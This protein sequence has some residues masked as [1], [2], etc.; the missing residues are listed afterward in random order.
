M[1][2][3]STTTATRVPAH[4]DLHTIPMQEVVEHTA[5]KVPNFLARYEWA[6][7]E[8]TTHG[9]SHGARSLLFAVCYRAGGK[10]GVCFA[11][12]KTLAEDADLHESR[13]KKL[14]PQLVEKG[15]LRRWRRSGAKRTYDYQPTCIEPAG[16]VTPQDSK[17]G[18]SSPSQDPESIIGA[19]LKVS[20]GHL[21]YIRTRTPEQR[22]SE[23]HPLQGEFE[24]TVR[25]YRDVNGART[26]S[27]FARRYFKDPDPEASLAADVAD[28]QAE[29]ERRRIAAEET[30]AL[31]A[32]PSTSRLPAEVRKYAA[33]GIDNAFIDRMDEKYADSPLSVLDEIINALNHV[34]VDK[35]KSVVLYVENWLRRGDDWEREWRTSRGGGRARRAEPQ[36]DWRIDAFGN[37]IDVLG[38]VTAE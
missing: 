36:T 14:L 6:S 23:A 13:V 4:P 8:S 34:A 9:L 38:N 26:I 12:V 15:L 19:P 33:R 20:S 37:R 3:E 21:S 25:Q 5:P 11:S 32:D 16:I 31:G 2:K 28:W 29:R 30:G 18:E 17:R 27:A 35:S 1:A 24:E 22:E 10:T 7:R